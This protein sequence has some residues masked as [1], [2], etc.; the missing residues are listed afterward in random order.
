MLAWLNE[1]AAILVAV[2]NKGKDGLLQFHRLRGTVELKK[3]PGVSFFS[4]EPDH[5]H[6]REITGTSE[7]LLGTTDSKERGGEESY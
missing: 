2:F 6:K 3:A 1:L 7:K 4:T 5:R